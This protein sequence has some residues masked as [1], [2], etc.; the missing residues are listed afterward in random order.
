MIR[1]DLIC[2]HDH[3]FEGWFSSSDDYENQRK[4][5]LIQCPVCGS[6]KI[7]KAIMAPNV[8]T[9]RKKEDTAKK[10]L[11]MMNEMASKIREEIASKC[12]DVGD[13]FAEEARAM[14]YGEKP[15]RGIYGQATAD[16]AEELQDEG[17]AAL[18]LPDI[19]AP[20]LKKKLN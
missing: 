11:A 2:R 3:S 12:D 9:S 13:S 7:E 1:Y 14:H 19:I 5:R 17:I 20:K 15:E 16:E 8:S 10:Q 6:A 18:P 4:N